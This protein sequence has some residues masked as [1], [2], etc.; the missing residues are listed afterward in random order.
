MARKTYYRGGKAAPAWRGKA[1]RGGGTKGY[2]ALGIVTMID[3]A[4]SLLLS[5]LN[6][7]E[8]LHAVQ[9]DGDVRLLL[10]EKAAPATKKLD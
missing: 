2:L 3:L 10:T 6:R 8:V 5:L 7:R 9:E 1:K 4:L